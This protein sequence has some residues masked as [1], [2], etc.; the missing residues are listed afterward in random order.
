MLFILRQL[1]L[2]Q[3]SFYNTKYGHD[4]EYVEVSEKDFAD[5]VRSLYKDFLTIF[6]QQPMWPS[7]KHLTC[8]HSQI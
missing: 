3:K 2:D 6:G 7:L 5:R 1:V 8:A 4:Q